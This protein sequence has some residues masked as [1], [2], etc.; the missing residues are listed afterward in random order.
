MPSEIT[1]EELTK[2]MEYGTLHGRV[3]NWVLQTSFKNSQ[4]L[5]I[6]SEE[7]YRTN[8][9]NTCLR[10]RMRAIFSFAIS[11]YNPKTDPEFISF[12]RELYLSTIYLFPIG[13]IEFKA[14]YLNITF[15][16]I[17][18]IVEKDS[19]ITIFTGAL[20]PRDFITF[21]ETD[22]RDLTLQ[23][24]RNST[25]IHEIDIK[26]ID[27]SFNVSLFYN[28]LFN[29]VQLIPLI[30]NPKNGMVYATDEVAISGCLEEL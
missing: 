19:G 18:V 27:E 16:A 15:S 3:E 30:L 25:L 17:Y 4:Q 10:T 13:S 7:S 23:C 12:I 22:P 6:Y 5:K 11:H 9:I 14:K 20:S 28:N 1:V 2:L 26:I 8:S 24:F 29:L 21:E